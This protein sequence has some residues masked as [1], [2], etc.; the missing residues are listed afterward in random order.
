MIHLIGGE[1]VTFSSN[2][3]VNNDNDYEKAISNV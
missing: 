1:K 2:T 3:Y